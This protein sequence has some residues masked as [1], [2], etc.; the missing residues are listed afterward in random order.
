MAEEVLKEI[1]AV[2]FPNL[3]KDIHLQVQEV[4]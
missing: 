1:M 2:N 4:E 3:A